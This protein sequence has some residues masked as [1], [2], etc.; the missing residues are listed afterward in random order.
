MSYVSGS[1]WWS[2]G[3]MSELQ[4]TIEIQEK[5]SN[6]RCLRQALGIQHPF[7]P[8]FHLLNLTFLEALRTTQFWLTKW[9]Q[10]CLF[11]LTVLFTCVWGWF[12]IEHWSYVCHSQASQFWIT[13]NLVT[14]S[15][16]DEIGSLTTGKLLAFQCTGKIFG[17][18]SHPL[19]AEHRAGSTQDSVR[20]DGGNSPSSWHQLT[21][22]SFQPCPKRENEP[23]QGH[24]S[25]NRNGSITWLKEGLSARRLQSNSIK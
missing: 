7:S 23:Q 22:C 2:S 12:L 1:D 9:K 16:N 6:A 20:R 13:Q 14:E 3:P 19:D 21:L 4:G 18:T 25:V 17:L 24:Q 10:C 8:P 15:E 5:D 11:C